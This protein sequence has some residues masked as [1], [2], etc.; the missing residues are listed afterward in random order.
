MRALLQG[1]GTIIPLP[2]L[3]LF[4]WKDVRHLICGNPEV[5]L[6]LLK[7]HTQY[8]GGITAND[9]HIQYFW[10][11]LEEFTPRERSLFLRF[12]WGR[13][14][15]PP[16]KEFNEEMKI[17]PNN[18][19]NHDQQL[20]HADTCFFNLALPAYSTADLMKQKILIAITHTMAMDG[21]T[22]STDPQDQLDFGVRARR[23]A[24]G[25]V[26]SD[27]YEEDDSIYE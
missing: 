18:K 25:F 3:S 4:T 6:N 8:R 16:E 7:K 9:P 2:L 17:F 12:T 26:A 19:G 10:K 27:G 11:V 20:P 23:L 15:L 24:R 22:Q 5:D 14:R 13:E 21:D 1:L